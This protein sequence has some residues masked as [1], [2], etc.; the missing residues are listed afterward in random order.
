MKLK[1]AKLSPTENMTIIVTSPVPRQQQAAVSEKLMAY[2][3]VYAEQVGFLEEASLP[4]TR[5]RLQMMG[6]EFCGNASMSMAT[7]LA[8]QDELPDG[9]EESYP[10][11][12]SGAEGAVICHIRRR[13]ESYTGT[14]S[15][16]VPEEI[17]RVE[18]D[19]GV[20]LPVVRFPGISHVIA[21]EDEMDADTACAVIARWCRQMGTDA[22]GILLVNREMTSMRPLVYVRETDSAVW[23]RGCGSG[24][25][26][27]GAYAAMLRENSA[28]LG[29][30][31]PGGTIRV[32]AAWNQG[33]TEQIQISGTVKIAAIG[34][35]FLE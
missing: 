34:E 30:Q 2:G 10:L 18:I 35:A 7:L 31:Q 19:P 8:W 25:A 21:Y 27:L 29:I 26:A 32:Q 1:F 28:D 9:A 16:P 15:M 13:G 24:T 5:V 22:L 4:G 14:I 20:C 3:S 17:S 33:K 6:G 12:V 11:E 23:E